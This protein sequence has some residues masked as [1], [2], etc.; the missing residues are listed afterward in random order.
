MRSCEEYCREED[1]GVVVEASSG[2]QCLC[3]DDPY[4]VCCGDCI[5]VNKA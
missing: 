3:D 2:G 4:R 1:G 5:G